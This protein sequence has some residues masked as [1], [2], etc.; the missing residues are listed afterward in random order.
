MIVED[1][2]D[3]L[4][5]PYF[6][7]ERKVLPEEVTIYVN[8]T[9]QYND[10]TG[11][12]VENELYTGET[13]VHLLAKEGCDKILR[14]LLDLKEN[15]KIGKAKLVEALLKH[16]GSGWSP[17]MSVVKAD[18][19]VEAI[20]EMFLEFLEEEADVEDVKKMIRIP[21]EVKVK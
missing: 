7:K 17:L 10:D 15:P 18:Q 2:P 12:T 20:A 14:R 19:N 11:V 3:I 5:E 1:N 8:D 13:I 9:L 6:K 4:T 21:K 16:D